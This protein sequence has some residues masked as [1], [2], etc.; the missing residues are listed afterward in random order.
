MTIRLPLVALL[1]YIKMGIISTIFNTPLG[2]YVRKQLHFSTYFH[3]HRFVRF[4]LFG[5]HSV[6]HDNPDLTSSIVSSQLT[7]ISGVVM[8]Q[9]A[10]ARA[11][12]RV[13]RAM[14]RAERLRRIAKL[15]SSKTP[16]QQ[17]VP[18]RHTTE[19]VSRTKASSIDKPTI[20]NDGNK[21]ETFKPPSNRE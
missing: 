13:Y 14:Q 3:L 15:D 17:L 7:T 21:S 2:F 12:M 9:V 19:R 18:P 10:G 5:D 11:D 6:N 4:F 16:P 20:V 8:I 1:K